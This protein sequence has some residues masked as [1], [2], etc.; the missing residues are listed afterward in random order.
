[1]PTGVVFSPTGETAPYP[2]TR[3]LASPGL[4]DA[5]GRDTHVSVPSPALAAHG[6]PGR[7][8]CGA[9]SVGVRLVGGEA[10]MPGWG[11]FGRW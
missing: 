9:R 10:R 3:V 11:G 6:T 2:A 8:A 7:G 5:N 4:G 1:M